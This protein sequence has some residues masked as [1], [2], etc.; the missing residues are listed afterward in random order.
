MSTEPA[1]VPSEQ[2][3]SSPRVRQLHWR[4]LDTVT[5]GQDVCQRKSGQH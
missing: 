2:D 1:T 3:S 5:L 4:Q